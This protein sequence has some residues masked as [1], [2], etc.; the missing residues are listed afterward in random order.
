MAG[1]E[2]VLVLVTKYGPAGLGA[3]FGVWLALVLARVWNLYRSRDRVWPEVVLL[4]NQAD[5]AEGVVRRLAARRNQNPDLHPVLVDGGST[6]D[7][8]LIL[9]RL[10]WRLNLGWGRLDELAGTGTR[11]GPVGRDGP[12]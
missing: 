11:R 4:L 7:T 12:D 6:D 3:L 5:C 1:Q 2:M 8:P 9:E 10:A